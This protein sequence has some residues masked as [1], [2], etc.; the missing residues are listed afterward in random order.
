[1]MTD[2]SGSTIAPGDRRLSSGRWVGVLLAA[3]VALIA[4]VARLLPVLRGSGLYGYGNY[5]DGVYFASA[6]GLT[7]GRLPYR[8]FLLLHP[9]GIVVALAPFA[10]LAH[11]SS[12]AQAF[13]IARL[14]WMAMGGL[15][16]VLVLIILWPLGRYS[17]GFGGLSYALFYP[18]VYSEHT[19]LLEAPATAALLI[20]LLIISR[21]PK[22]WAGGRERWSWMVAGSCLGLLPSFKIWG[23][24]PVLVVAI[25]VAVTRGGRPLSRLLI[26][27]AASAVA[28]MGPFFMMAPASMWRLV[29]LD[30][31]GRGHTSASLATRLWAIAGLGLYHR[32]GGRGLLILVG[33]LVWLALTLCAAWLAATRLFAILHVA[34]GGLLLITPSWFPHYA[35]LIAPTAAL[36][37]GGA[38][39]TMAARLRPGSIRHAFRGALVTAMVVL[40]VLPLSRA[41][42]GKALPRGALTSG[43]IG[44]AGCV[45]TDDPANLIELN[46]LDRNLDRGCRLVVDVGGYSYDESVAGRQVP[47]RSNSVWQRTLLDYLR[48]G[49]VTVLSRFGSQSTFSTTTVVT[50]HRW[51]LLARFGFVELRVPSR[52]A[53]PG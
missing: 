43:V 22:L 10:A 31:L 36:V 37:L 20:A 38:A 7:E 19:T 49:S 40:T 18:A 46:V 24:V 44:A 52:T 35:A 2:Q 33:G 8:D 6:A 26:G 11:V 51:P 48:S 42:L 45:T 9:P 47:R 4:F 30:Q 32:P 28:V 3:A 27:A 15:S 14:A 13:A 21:R 5:D 16:S 50:I 41:S 12:D 53:R 39:T 29:V 25:W 23:V 1:M 17:A 34:L